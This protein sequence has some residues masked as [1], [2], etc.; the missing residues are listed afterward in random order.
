MD[1]TS[2]QP[3]GWYPGPDGRPRW[4]TGQAWVDG[5][6]PGAPK[7]IKS[8][9]YVPVRTSHTFHLLMTVFT[10]GLWGLFVWFPLTVL[11]KMSRRKVVT[12]Y[13]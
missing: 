11:H 6:V 5:A 8:V 4:W 3:A 1:A 7:P 12:R 10:C 13:R 2:R 9:T